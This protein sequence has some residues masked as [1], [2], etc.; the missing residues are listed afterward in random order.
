MG[1]QGMKEL[2]KLTGSFLGDISQMIS[3]QQWP[4]S[5]EKPENMQMETGEKP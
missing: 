2:F 5:L 1:P 3:I 4:T